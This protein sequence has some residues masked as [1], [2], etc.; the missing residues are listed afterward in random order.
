MTKDVTKGGKRHLALGDNMLSY[1]L[2]KAREHDSG[3]R[4]RIYAVAVDKKGRVIAEGGN[5]Y[6]ISHPVQQHYATAAGRPLACFLHA[7]IRVLAQL[8]RSRKVCHTLYIAR[9]KRNGEA[10]LAQPC[11]ICE[12]AL[13]EAGIER[14]IWTTNN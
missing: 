1:S 11:T 14:I 3:G 2:S 7:E 6:T 4:Q 12:R 8:V 10:G 9:A 13:Q 5:S